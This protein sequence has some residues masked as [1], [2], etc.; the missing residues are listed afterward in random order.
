MR[1]ATSL[2]KKRW[3]GETHGAQT[4]ELQRWP[5]VGRVDEGVA[6]CVTS[7]MANHE[8]IEVEHSDEGMDSLGKA[9][10]QLQA[11]IYPSVRVAVIRVGPISGI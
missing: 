3:R 8:N 9:C 6:T 2:R 1:Q 5:K 11:G 10:P 7:P 4:G